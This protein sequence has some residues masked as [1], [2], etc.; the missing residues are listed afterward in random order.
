MKRD[1]VQPLSPQEQDD[2]IQWLSQWAQRHRHY[3]RL[4]DQEAAYAR[5]QADPSAPPA[6]PPQYDEATR[7]GFDVS[8]GQAAAIYASQLESAIRILALLA[9]HNGKTLDLDIGNERDLFGG[10]DVDARD[11]DGWYERAVERGFVR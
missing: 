4:R 6:E 11:G 9:R 5:F 8:P 10:G 1:P 7:R 2:L 3:G